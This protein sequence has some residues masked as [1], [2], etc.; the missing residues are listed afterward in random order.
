MFVW[1]LLAFLLLPQMKMVFNA[2]SL[3]AY[4]HW[5]TNGTMAKIGKR[6]KQKKIKIKIKL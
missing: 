2:F 4:D 1:F 5:C 6:P 3:F